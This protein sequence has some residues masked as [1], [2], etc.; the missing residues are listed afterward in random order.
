M[1]KMPILKDA[2]WYS[3]AY[4]GFRGCDFTTDAMEISESRSPD[5]INMIAD[6]AGLLQKRVG[7][8]VLKKFTGRIN[9]LHYVHL[10][11]MTDPVII[12]HHGTS[13]S[14]FNINTYTATLISSSVNDAA[15]SALIHGG[16][17]YLLD[18]SHFYQLSYSSGFSLQLV[19]A[20]AKTPTTGR[21]GHYEAEIEKDENNDDVTVYTW[22]ACTSY[23]EP[24]ILSSKQ[25]HLLAGD[26]VNTDFWLTERGVTVNKVEIYSG[27]PGSWSTTTAYTKT[28]DATVGKTKIA[29]TSAPAAHPEG[30]G[31]DNIRI[32]FTSAEHPADASLIDHCTIATQYGYFNNNR[33]FVSGNPSYKNRDWA[34]DVEDPSYWPLYQ[35]TDVGSDHT[36]IMGYLHYGDALAIIKQ[37]DNQDSEIYM[38]QAVVQT[39]N[40]VIFPVQQ[41]VKGVGAI[42][43]GGFATLRDDA[44]FY[45]REGVFAVSG[46]DASQQRTVQNRSYFVDK[47]L[48]AEPNKESAVAAVWLDKFLLSFPSS[49]HCYVADARQ[50]TAFNESFVYEW[51]Y[52]ENIHACRFLEFDGNL[53]FGT[54][55]GELCR[56]N[57]DFT[58]SKKYYD[59]LVR[60]DNVSDPLLE[61]TSWKGGDGILARWTTRMDDMGIPNRHKTLMKRGC[62]YV[63]KTVSG[64]NFRVYATTEKGERITISDTTKRIR[65]LWD[66]ANIDF[67]NIRFD[68]MRTP[69]TY[70]MNKKIKKFIILQLIFENDEPGE[71]FGVVSVM[72]QYMVNNYIK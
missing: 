33:F 25:I 51:F 56:F 66:F 36:A 2:K 53:F 26:G 12:V 32:T 55:N 72:L 61:S 54:L 67:A 6:D 20:N 41:G 37:D 30:A 16:K 15:S 28:E 39:D 63:F 11:G 14:A 48:R 1:I 49:G 22:V 40:Y 42:A 60:V 19:S 8:R 46:T 18:G 47:K 13:L 3:K 9:G 23:E 70:A 27:S 62:A 21:G 50:Q 64:G 68:S 58:S 65:T 59:G 34:C 17:M 69:P 57:S 7:W 5:C 10:N 38:R 43:H 44:L 31:L 45:A 35:W 71:D 52:W 4:G 24:N 29:F